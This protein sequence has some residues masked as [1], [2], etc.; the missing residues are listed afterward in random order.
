VMGPHRIDEECV[1]VLTLCL[2]EIR[3]ISFD[4]FRCTTGASLLVIAQ[5]CRELRSIGLWK[6]RAG[7][8]TEDALVT[9]F[10]YLPCLEE[11]ELFSAADVSDD[12]LTTIAKK[13]PRLHTLELA[14]TGGFTEVGIAA[15]AEGCRNLEV[16]Y[17]SA[18]DERI[19]LLCVCVCRCG[20]SCGRNSRCILRRATGRAGRTFAPMCRKTHTQSTGG[21]S[22]GLYLVYNGLRLL[23]CGRL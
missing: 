3:H 8:F 11:L 20:S 18:N 2:A 5:H 10:G 13:C 12:V 1:T 22:L 14:N 21:K 19:S 6:L 17:L 4:C 9:L 15:L 7:T 16:L 23:A